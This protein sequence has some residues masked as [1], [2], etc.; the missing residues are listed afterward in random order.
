[1]GWRE[2]AVL[3]H[4]ERHSHV[5][6]PGKQNRKTIPG[7]GQG[8]GIPGGRERSPR[9]RTRCPRRAGASELLAVA[10]ADWR[11]SQCCGANGE[12]PAGEF[13]CLRPA[14]LERIRPAPD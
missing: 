3:Y 8:A 2:G 9:W 12:N 14:L 4:K 6:A 7:A 13:L 1:M 11:G 5:V 10:V